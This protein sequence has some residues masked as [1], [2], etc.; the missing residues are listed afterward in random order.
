M[1]PA[2]V[3]PGCRMWKVQ[4]AQHL[5]LHL[6][7]DPVVGDSSLILLAFKRVHWAQGF[8]NRSRKG[9][10]YQGYWHREDW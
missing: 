4:T 5:E 8:W 6:P 3:A 7:S 2:A 10:T 9:L 1:N